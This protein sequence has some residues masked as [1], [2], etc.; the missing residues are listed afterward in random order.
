[1]KTL[2]DISSNII[3]LKTSLCEGILAGQDAIIK[4]GDN[5][6]KHI[7]QWILKSKSKEEFN[8][9]CELLK[10]MIT[11]TSTP[12]ENDVVCYITSITWK[13]TTSYFIEIG[14]FN[15][16][17]HY[18]LMYEYG[19]LDVDRYNKR[20]SIYHT[21]NKSSIYGVLPKDIITKD[22]L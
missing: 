11:P 8:S 18:K 5:V 20:I 17:R 1:M 21:D 4:D 12:D 10:D 19:R 2:K 7:L 22:L 14:K 9:Y 15:K 16:K 6:D 13:G 3:S